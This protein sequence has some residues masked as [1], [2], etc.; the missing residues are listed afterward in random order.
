MSDKSLHKACLLCFLLGVIPSFVALCFAPWSLE[1]TLVF[2]SVMVVAGWFGTKKIACCSVPEA[3]THL[4]DK[5]D[6]V[7]AGDSQE[8]KGTQHNSCSKNIEE[9]N[10]LIETH[11]ERAANSTSAAAKATENATIIASAIEELNASISEIGVQAEKS[12]GQASSAVE[13]TK[14]ATSSVEQL[15]IR[16]EEILS[17]IGLIQEIARHTNLL[18]LNA[19]IEAAR[20]GDHGKGFAVVAKEV[21]DLARQT[22]D[23]TVKIEEQLNEV[24]AA[25]QAVAD[26]MRTIGVAIA[27]IDAT[28]ETIKTSLHEEEQAV[29]EIAKSAQA[30]SLATTEV[31][32]GISHMLVTTEDIRCNVMNLYGNSI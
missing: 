19:T 11:Q 30:T 32:E 27:E 14:I 29:Q 6:L 1:E 22:A 3:S 20:A 26:H 25:S 9:I 21:K 15:S 5:V 12:S 7:K 18:A 2:L 10:V 31:T 16:S 8:K 23:A 17:I 13:K 28:A 24:R 4:T